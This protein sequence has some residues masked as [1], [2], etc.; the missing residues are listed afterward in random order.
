MHKAYVGT[1][2]F[3]LSLALVWG[4]MTALRHELFFF[5]PWIDIPMH[6]LGGVVIGLLAYF[7]FIAYSSRHENSVQVRHAVTN[8]LL[9]V[10]LMGILWEVYEVIFNL[11]EEFNYWQDTLIDLLMDM[12]GGLAVAIW[13]V[14]RNEKLHMFHNES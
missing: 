3:I 9:A 10:F 5:V 11:T 6:F 12:S 1:M 4:Y 13:V 8:V 14:H 7:I 2:L